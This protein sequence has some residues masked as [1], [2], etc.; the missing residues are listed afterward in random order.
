M[1]SRSGLE[2][3]CPK[4]GSP[5]SR[6]FDDVFG[7]HPAAQS[8]A[9]RPAFGP[10]APR[11]LCSFP[12]RCSVSRAAAAHEGSASPNSADPRERD[13]SAETL[14]LDQRHLQLQNQVLSELERRR[15]QRGTPASPATEVHDSPLLLI[16]GG[17]EPRGLSGCLCEGQHPDSVF[18]LTVEYGSA[19]RPPACATSS[20]PMAPTTK[21][22][23]PATPRRGICRA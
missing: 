6:H 14:A 7:R 13:P 8:L 22:P 1:R 15:A 23:R 10:S 16:F 20:R 19:I 4:V 11:R 17:S 9:A 2:C 21:T 5:R 3:S 12:W 18:N